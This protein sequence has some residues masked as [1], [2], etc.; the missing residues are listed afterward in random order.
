MEC[1]SRCARKPNP[2]FDCQR[3]RGKSVKDLPCD[4]VCLSY[5]LYKDIDNRL[6]YNNFCSECGRDLRQENKK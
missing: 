5:K 2:C 6:R 1:C 4:D 3:N